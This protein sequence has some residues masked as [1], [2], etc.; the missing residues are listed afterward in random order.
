MRWQGQ[1][2]SENVEDRRRVGGKQ[3]AVGGGLGGL[4]IAV[5]FMLLG[6]KSDEVLQTLQQTAGPS[7]AESGQPLSEKDKLMG[8]FVAVILAETE[9]VWGTIFQ[10][11]GDQYRKP[12]L[13]L[14]TNQTASGCGTA[15]AYSGPF[16]C[17]EDEKVY[18]DLG[19]FEQMQERLGAQG[20]FA[21]AY[22]I[23]HEVGHHVQR[24]LGIT[25]KVFGQQGRVGEREFNQL[26]V[27]LELQ[28]DFLA[29]V[30]AYHT[31]RN[32]NIIEEGD[33]E[34]GINAASAVGDD[35]LQKQSQGYIVPDSFTHGTSEQRV[36]WFTK[37]LRTGDVSQGDTFS[38]RAL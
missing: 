33:I 15:S 7:A 19:F 26:M 2:K 22:V 35:R 18:L 12:K 23:S 25:E 38:A 16:Y 10:Q 21:L 6:G 28:A 37:G 1:R 9:D 11:S 31:Q 27:R 4:I 30:W 17:P 13:V 14:F 8:D 32:K 24:L 34:E 20:D 29:G 5:L 3:L 36:R